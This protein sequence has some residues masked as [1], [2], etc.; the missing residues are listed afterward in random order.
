MKSTRKPQRA[1]TR[2]RRD[3]SPYKV[4]ALVLGRKYQARGRT[5][6]EAVSKL[7]VP[8]PKGRAILVVEH[9]DR[10][11]ERVLMP[12]LVFRL[13]AGGRMSKEVALKHVSLL[14]DV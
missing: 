11:K 9:G 6:V 14:F 1:K 12:P 13:F 4:T 8:H 3:G 7:A 10:L 5:I 2:P